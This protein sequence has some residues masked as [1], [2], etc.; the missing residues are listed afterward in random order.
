MGTWLSETD[1]AI[2]EFLEHTGVE[3][4]PKV[5]HHNIGADVSKTQIHRRLK[6]LR[7]TGI[8]ERLDEPSG[9]YRLSDLGCDLVNGQLSRKE[10][11]ELEPSSE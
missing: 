2:L 11:S 9:Y 6:K 3:A 5:I 8:V 10:I 7:E 1:D 4:P